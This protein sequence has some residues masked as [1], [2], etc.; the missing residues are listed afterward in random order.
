MTER[1]R[2]TTA[3]ATASYFGAE[4]MR[5]PAA[6]ASLVRRRLLLRGCR[7]A[8]RGRGA[9]EDGV[10]AAGAREQDGEADGAAHKDDGGVGG[11]LGEEVGCAAG[12][13][14]RLR[15]LTAEG[16]GE[17]GR[18]A[19]LEKDDADEKERDDYVQDNEKNEHREAY[20]LLVRR[21]IPEKMCGLVRRRGLEPLCLAALAPQASASANFATSALC[22][23][24]GGRECAVSN[25]K[26]SIPSRAG[27]LGLGAGRFG[28]AAEASSVNRRRAAEGGYLAS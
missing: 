19:L 24:A 12:A 25:P 15:A 10:V 14:G 1:K 7:L 5:K 3:T 17:V 11:Q 4:K 20:D 16:T 26:G 6:C 27:W 23:D 21:R 2:K 22:L 18:F 28:E 9:R 8:G 13:E